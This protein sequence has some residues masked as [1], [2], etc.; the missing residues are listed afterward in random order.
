[1][2]KEVLSKHRKAL[3]LFGIFH[4]MHGMGG[5]VSKYEQD[6]PNVTFVI[7]EL[8]VFD[9]ELLRLSTSPFASWPI[10][11]LA[12][13]KGTWLGAL[14]LAHFLP[15]PITMDK[16]CNF[17]NEFPKEAQKQMENLVDSFLYL[18]PQDLRLSEQIPADIVLDDA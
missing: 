1:M 18:G 4:L 6:Y 13:A 9:T 12:R 7:S 16:E 17:H 14:E 3:M 11:S 2:E 5:A 15:P 10:P 8:G